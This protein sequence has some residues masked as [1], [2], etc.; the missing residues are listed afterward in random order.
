[1]KN[2]FYTMVFNTSIKN[3]F[4]KRLAF[5]LI[6][7]YSLAADSQVFNSA[8]FPV[9]YSTGAILEN[10]TGSTNATFSDITPTGLISFGGGFTFWFAGTNYTSISMSPDGWVRLGAP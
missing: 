3:H 2:I 1:M 5:L 7:F 9:Q 4:L 8:N 6:T 10:M